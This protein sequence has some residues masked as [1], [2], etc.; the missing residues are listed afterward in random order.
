MDDCREKGIER[1]NEEHRQKKDRLLSGLRQPIYTLY[2][3]DN[4]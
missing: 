4:L 2:K 1:H 3:Y